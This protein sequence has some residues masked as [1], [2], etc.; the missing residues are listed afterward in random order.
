VNAHLENVGPCI[1]ALLADGIATLDSID[2]QCPADQVDIVK[3]GTEALGTAYFE[4]HSG[5]T[6]MA[7]ATGD[8]H[9]PYSLCSIHP[10]FTV[11][12]WARAEAIM[13]DFVVKTKTEAGCVYYGWTRVGDQLKC[14][15]SYVDGA[16][17]NAHLENVGACIG[18][19]LAEGVATLDEIF[20]QC[21]ESEVAVVKPGTESLG[22][23]YFEVHSGFSKYT[24]ATPS[25]ATMEKPCC[26]GVVRNADTLT[27]ETITEGEFPMYVN[28]PADG[29]NGIGVMVIH[30]IFVV[31]CTPPPPSSSAS[32]SFP[33][34][35]QRKKEIKERGKEGKNSLPLQPPPTLSHL[36][37]YHHHR[38]S[39][40]RPSPLLFSLVPNCKYI[41]DY[42]AGQGYTAILPNFYVDTGAW[43]ATETEIEKPLEGDE[44]GAWFGSIM[45]EDFW[46]GHFS[47]GVD[48]AAGWLK[49]QGCSNLTT[50]GFCWGGKAVTVACQTNHFSAG[51]SL[52]GAAH[53]AADV[54]GSKCPL[55]F[56]AING[57]AFFPETVHEEIR[58]LG[59]EVKVY[60]EMYHGFVV[61]GDFENA[62]AVKAG[63][64]EAL[65]DTC[66]FFLK[67]CADSSARRLRNA[68][69]GSL[70]GFYEGWEFRDG[71]M[72][73]PRLAHA[74]RCPSRFFY[75]LE[76]VCFS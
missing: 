63:A 66:A 37:Q 5:F 36:L 1:N 31:V 34:R 61:R 47:K 51:V 10:T 25:A 14:R 35:E 41:V 32:S 65:T 28:R 57:D 13:E 71:G 38:P 18:A 46:A 24:L 29:G 70:A 75:C 62:P 76:G 56:V 64:E 43:P 9:L 60:P 73:C 50:M 11:T 53:S 12:D 33:V 72:C 3:P 19:I 22:T 52:H 6:N 30:D 7:S 15:E 48:A 21:P 54:T 23:A 59:T 27:G 40:P 20:I 17:V 67:N 8:A 2:I 4:I 39:S 58:A 49:A 44:F 69:R 42:L 55:F 16:A 45:G 74:R 26:V 68:V